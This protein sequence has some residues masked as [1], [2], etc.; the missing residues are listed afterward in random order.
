[1]A[2]R[3]TSYRVLVKGLDKPLAPCLLLLKGKQELL[4]LSGQALDKLLQPGADKLSE[5][6]AGSKY[7]SKNSCNL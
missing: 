4:Q 6:V 5:G 2:R 3:K 7:P 1:M